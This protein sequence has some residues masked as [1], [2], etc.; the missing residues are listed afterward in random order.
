MKCDK[1]VRIFAP[2]LYCILILIQ[3]SY[4]CIFKPIWI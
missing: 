4:C 2:L 3:M 1:N